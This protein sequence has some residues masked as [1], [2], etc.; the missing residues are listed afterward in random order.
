MVFK[1]LVRR[2]LVIIGLRT[3]GGQLMQN[4]PNPPRQYSKRQEREEIEKCIDKGLEP[5]YYF[6]IFN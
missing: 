1:P 3:L 6:S 2:L 5:T 4:L